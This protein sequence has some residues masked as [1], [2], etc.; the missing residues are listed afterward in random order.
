M[1]LVD[2]MDKINSNIFFSIKGGVMEQ[3]SNI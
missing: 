2:K 1:P 3:N